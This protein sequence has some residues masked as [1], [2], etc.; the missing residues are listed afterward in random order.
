MKAGDPGTSSGA[1][2]GGVLPY[3]SMLCLSKR[4]DGLEE[5]GRAWLKS[6]STLGSKAV[7]ASCT[8]SV[9]LVLLL[10][11]LVGRAPLMS[12]TARLSWSAI[13]VVADAMRFEKSPNDEGITVP[14]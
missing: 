12:S 11:L 3:S 1:D 14:M 6:S 2:R 9:G 5:P 10:L 8:A 7:F 13:A 4:L